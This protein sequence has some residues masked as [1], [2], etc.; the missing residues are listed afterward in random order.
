M[1]MESRRVFLAD[2]SD[3]CMIMPS[4]SPASLPLQCCPHTMA[5]VDAP[6]KDH[7][8]NVHESL[9]AVAYPKPN[10]VIQRSMSI[11]MLHVHRFG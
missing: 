2:S 10:Q 3:V 11:T 9:V 5:L 6:G 8:C 1:E 7:P 4:I